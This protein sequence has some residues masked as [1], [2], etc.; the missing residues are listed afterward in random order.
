MRHRMGAA[1][2]SSAVACVAGV[3][4]APAGARAQFVEPE[5]ELIRLFEGAEV[6]DNF[7]WVSADLGDLDGDG[8][9]DFAISAMGH[10]GFAGR[11]YIFSGKRGT[12]LNQVDG[13]PGATLGLS[14]DSA[15]DVDGDCTPD[16]ILGGGQVLVYSGADHTLL[17]DLTATTGVAHSVRGVG[18]LDGDGLDD[19]A[20]G[21]QTASV[22]FPQAGRIYAL[23]GADG[24]IL[25]TRDGDGQGHNLGSAVGA[26]GDVNRD[27]VPD[28]VAGAFG[29][30]TGGEA[31]LLDGNDGST[32]R[33]LAPVDPQAAAVFGQ[34]F[35]S[36]AGDVNRDGVGDAF[37][38]DYAAGGGSGTATVYSG[39]TG[40]VLHHI[41]GAPGD[42]V[43]PGRGIPDVNGDRVP[44]I[45]VAAWTSSDGAPRAGKALLYSGKS[46]ALLRTITAT[47]PQDNFG[48]DAIAVGDSDG[49]R[50]TDY[51]VTA[52]GLSFAGQDVGRAYLVAGTVLPCP[53]DLDGNRRVNGRDLRLLRRAIKRGDTRG[54]LDGSGIA[55]ARD[56]GVLVRDLGRCPSGRPSH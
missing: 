6:G 24:S 20:V 52:V 9:H 1:Q 5:A 10:G 34:F 19:L 18:D 50:L 33:V 13:A 21:S 47:A 51:L 44:D 46:G 43:G 15:G 38:A 39:R 32:L 56:V 41:V 35:A 22:S 25:W 54:D 26:V 29:A 48:V 53:A 4:L 37:V 36:G 12:L 49:D 7:G 40:R 30:G 55:D 11:V 45:F 17:L 27:H 3:L 23:S 14:L 2:A 42:G 31:Y 8:H 28:L 16:Y